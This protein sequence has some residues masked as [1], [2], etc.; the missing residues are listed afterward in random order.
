MSP[1]PTTIVTCVASVAVG[2]TVSCQMNGGN[3]LHPGG[4]PKPPIGGAVNPLPLG[5]IGLWGSVPT[6]PL[7]P[8]NA[9]PVGP[10]GPAICNVQPGPAEQVSMNVTDSSAVLP[11]GGPSTGPGV[12]AASFS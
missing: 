1:V 5:V 11:I 3:V 6:N 8:T 10:P 7:L 4:P 9:A 12:P 2:V